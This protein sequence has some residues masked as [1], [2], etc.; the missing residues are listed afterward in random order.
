MPTR[1]IL[2]TAPEIVTLTLHKSIPVVLLLAVVRLTSLFATVVTAIF[3]QIYIYD[4]FIKS[5]CLVPKEK[6]PQLCGCE[7]VPLKEI[8]RYRAVLKGRAEKQGK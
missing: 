5:G 7:G 8:R 2:L 4:I 6:L 1:Y 3:L